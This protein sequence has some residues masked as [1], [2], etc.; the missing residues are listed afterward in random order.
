M[1]RALKD[2]KAICFFVVPALVWFC[3]IALIPVFQSAGYSLLDWD[4]IREAKFIGIDN[5]MK[6]FQDPLFFKAVW[7]SF[8]LAAASVFIQLPISM[9]LALVLGRGNGLATGIRR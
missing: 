3:A 1:E 8:L 6:M 5:Y 2:K 4:G 7:N 9:V